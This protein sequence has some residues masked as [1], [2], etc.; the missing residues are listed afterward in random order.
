MHRGIGGA[1]GRRGD[2]RAHEAAAG[3]PARQPAGTLPQPKTNSVCS[4]VPAVLL[5]LKTTVCLATNRRARMSSSLAALH[6]SAL[7]AHRAPDFDRAL[8]AVIM[9][10]DVL[11]RVIESV[12]ADA[13][14]RV[15]QIYEAGADALPILT[16]EGTAPRASTADETSVVDAS[17]AGS[18]AGFSSIQ[19]APSP[20]GTVRHVP[21]STAAAGGAAAPP[22]LERKPWPGAS[23][24][25]WQVA[26]L[27]H[28]LSIGF[29]A[30]HVPTSRVYSGRLEQDEVR[31]L[32]EE[33]L[34]YP[35]VA[36]LWMVFQRQSSGTVRRTDPRSVQ[37]SGKLPSP[38]KEGQ[39]LT[40]VADLCTDDASNETLLYEDLASRVL[41][42]EASLKT[43]R[44]LFQD[45]VNHRSRYFLYSPAWVVV[46]Q[47]MVVCFDSHMV[48][49][50]SL[51]GGFIGAKEV[52]WR[53]DNWNPRCVRTGGARSLVTSEGGRWGQQ[54]V[55]WWML[56]L[57]KDPD[58]IVIDPHY[59]SGPDTRP[60]PQ[61]DVFNA[62]QDL[63]R[64]ALVDKER[65]SRQNPR[66][67][68]EPHCYP[69][70][71]L[72][73][74]SE[75]D[76]NER[77][78]GS[79][80]I[81][82]MLDGEASEICKFKLPVEGYVMREFNFEKAAVSKCL[83]WMVTGPS[84]KSGENNTYFVFNLRK[85][86]LVQ[87]FQKRSPR[88]PSWIAVSSNCKIFML[89]YFQVVSDKHVLLQYDGLTGQ[90][91]KAIGEFLP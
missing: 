62:V 43:Q 21:A 73:Y 15:R 14:R 29:E 48:K 79:I 90:F 33:A 57:D 41:V 80:A 6:A 56:Y 31:R 2:M 91:V 51:E 60:A 78:K 86:T 28:D 12:D 20:T 42:L 63:Q 64:Q 59:G 50:F 4:C 46:V 30:T 13:V 36:A 84:Q 74:I 45:F 40:F 7:S 35:G 10:S 66:L 85:G 9:S 68:V 11:Q 55:Q 19:R 75:Y 39:L 34:I 53:N 3:V 18:V 65:R 47:N 8:S 1:P 37:L 49:T 70:E 89:E 58:Y 82:S 16:A 61:T 67:C 81:L 72:F 69:T 52:S 22:P 38:M 5:F 83:T 44:Q 32:C 54:P 27:R 87:K 71:S 24:D 77:D 88:A 76:Q 17:D 25:Q 23:T 26:L